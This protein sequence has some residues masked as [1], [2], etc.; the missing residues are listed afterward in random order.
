MK[1]IFR[2]ETIVIKIIGRECHKLLNRQ[3][4]GIILWTK[5][6]VKPIKKP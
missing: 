5:L 6:E 2:V 3:E 1:L 4:L